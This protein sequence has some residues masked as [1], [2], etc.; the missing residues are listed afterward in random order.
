M[1]D[2]KPVSTASG[3]NGGRPI[4]TSPTTTRD[5]EE[6]PSHTDHIVPGGSSSNNSGIESGV[7]P[8]SD[9]GDIGEVP[10]GA[11][12]DSTSTNGDGPASSIPT[13]SAGLPPNGGTQDDFGTLP[14]TLV[15]TPPIPG[16]TTL[17]SDVASRTAAPT[18]VTVPQ[19]NSAMVRSRPVWAFVLTCLFYFV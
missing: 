10:A 11:A 4:D 14:P 13:N 2:T 18:A 3:S 5:G 8:K 19:A 7:P 16:V 9:G 1:S 17:T 12:S 6:P 15:S